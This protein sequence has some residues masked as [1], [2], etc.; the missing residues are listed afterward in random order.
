MPKDRYVLVL[1]HSP[2]QAGKYARRKGLR[3][4]T[5]RAVSSAGSIRGIQVADVHILP[6]F[7]ARMD[8]HAILA[9]LRY[10]R[11]IVK[12]DVEMPEPAEEVPVDQGDGMGQQLSLDSLIAMEGKA[13]LRPDEVERL[14][15]HKSVDPVVELVP[16]NQQTS[17]A[18]F[19]QQVESVTTMS[20]EEQ[21]ELEKAE[22]H[23]PKRRRSRCKT[24]GRLTYEDFETST[25]GHD[26]EAHA[27]VLSRTR[28]QIWED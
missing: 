19:F 16:A 24:C 6:E 9:E 13:A 17:D 18:V 12:M 20:E 1:A 7:H 5:Y 3:P 21:A 22:T 25:E 11:D 2:Q 26:A 28:A 14:N 23:K 8:S 27:P 10:G 15:K 4:G